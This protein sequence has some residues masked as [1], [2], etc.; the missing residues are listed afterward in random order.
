M[1]QAFISYAE[2]DKAFARR[3]AAELRK[4]GIDKV[5]SS[6]RLTTPGEGWASKIMDAIV[7]S[8]VVF[9]LLSSRSVQSQWIGTETALALSKASRGGHPRVIPVLL[10]PNV[11]LPPLLRSIQALKLFDEGRAEEELDAVARSL[12]AGGPGPP[13]DT[14][15]ERQAELSFISASKEALK[16]EIDDHDAKRVA[17]T[18][19]ISTGI[20]IFILFS[21]SLV[22]TQLL[23][24]RTNYGE[25]FLVR[26]R[27]HWSTL[28]F[29]V[30]SLV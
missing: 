21:L 20:V 18:I 29:Y 11:E 6:D 7:N 19:K 17:T 16:A 2:A 22:V 24:L 10:G 15:H 3:L 28:C 27:W 13:S 8:D 25:L 4:R 5:V 23:W 12:K 14:A 30:P 1:V 26:I 9:V